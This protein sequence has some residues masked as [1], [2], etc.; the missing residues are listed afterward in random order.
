MPLHL[1]KGDEPGIDIAMFMHAVK[2]QLGY[3][4]RLVKPDDLRLVS[5]PQDATKKLLCCLATNPAEKSWPTFYTEAGELVEEIRQ[6]GLE[7]YQREIR[8]LDHEMLRQVSLRCFNDLRTIL[9]VHDKRMLG[10]IR[11]EIPSLVSRHV[12]TPAQ[13]AAL[14][15]GISETLVPGSAELQSLLARSIA[16]PSLRKEYIFKPIRDGKG[17]GIIFCD[18]ITDDEWLTTLSGLQN[19]AVTPS[20]AVVQRHV[21]QREYSIVLQRTGALQRFPIVGTYHAMHG[22][23]L[24]IGIWRASGER[25]CAIST[26][27]SWLCSVMRKEGD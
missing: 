16:N 18:A 26:G 3:V 27:G 12:L 11:Q 15:R 17:R 25:I 6:V 24:G 5:D 14:E 13:G 20:S 22:K 2:Q 10:I 8:N 23:Y 21:V 1:L 9:L 19:A 4:P 7:L